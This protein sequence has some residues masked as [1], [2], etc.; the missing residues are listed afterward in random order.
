MDEA[1]AAMAAEVFR[2]YLRTADSEAVTDVVG[3]AVIDAAYN[4]IHGM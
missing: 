4:L 2:K 3:K 1:R